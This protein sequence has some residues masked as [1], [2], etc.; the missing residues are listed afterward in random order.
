M[1]ESVESESRFKLESELRSRWQGYSFRELLEL[2]WEALD[3]RGERGPRSLLR[4]FANS[5]L[6]ANILVRL[7]T[8]SSVVFYSILRR[9]LIA[10]HGMDVGRDASF[11]P[12]LVFP[13]PLG[14]VV[15]N[16]IVGSN[17]T[18]YQGV[19]IGHSHGESPIIGND[20][21]IY[22]GATIIGR[23]V[24]G[25]RATIGARAYVYSDV[26]PDTVFIGNR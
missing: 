17:V 16:A 11:G 21:T 20:V 6:H 2:D 15:G 9:F 4:A 7:A 18:I 23:V 1:V 14:I 26:A 22:A 12:G 25:D 19:T 5:S 8:R 10:L 24:I 3:R 13:H